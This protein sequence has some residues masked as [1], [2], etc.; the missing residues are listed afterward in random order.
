MPETHGIYISNPYGD[1]RGLDLAADNNRS[2]VVTGYILIIQP[3]IMT[4]FF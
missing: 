3:S 4:L 1:D 2:L